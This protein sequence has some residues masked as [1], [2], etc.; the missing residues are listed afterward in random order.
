MTGLSCIN[1]LWHEFNAPDKIPPDDEGSKDRMQTGIEVGHL[2]KKLHPKGIEI[3]YGS[4]AVHLTKEALKKRVPLFEASFCYKDCYCKVDL[5]V[6]VHDDEWDLYEVK[7]TTSAKGEHVEDVA[8][9]RYVLQKDGIKIRRAHVMFINNE[10]VKKGAIDVKK[11]FE[12]EDVTDL[13]DKPD[14][15]EANVERFLH[16]INGKK[17][18]IVYGQDC[19]SP[20]ECPI[21][22]QDIE[23]FELTKLVGFG[24]KFYPFLN[25]GITTFKQ[26]PK[27][28]KLTNKQ[29]IQLTS[30]P[31]T[32]KVAVKKFLDELTYPLY[33][34]DFESFAHAMPIHDGTRP[35]QAV[36]FQ[37][38]LHVIDKDKVEHREF[39]ADGAKDPRKELIKALKMIGS[40]G[41]V[42]M[43]TGFERKRLEELADYSKKDSKWIHKIIERLADL[44]DPF[45]TFDVYDPKQEG[46]YSIKA[47]LPAFIG[48]SYAEL[49]IGEGT[50][51]QR[52][53]LRVTYGKVSKEEKE[54]IRKALLTYCKHDTEAMVKLVNVL[55]SISK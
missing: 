6:P 36:P 5:L 35:Y 39:L 32:N 40:K 20:S 11:F 27:D 28:L 29:H 10:F 21:C 19:A 15:V 43:Y 53:Y 14:E 48:I 16:I 55:R 31:N 7:S 42:L 13:T 12:S 25:Q 34:L 26:L 51:A 49:D 37:F 38:S 50:M 4:G 17:P 33:C 52:E 45:R 1:L 44:S 24:K 41:S 9:Q 30:K 46:S 8:F 2:A 22:S 3:P 23:P 18:K 54:K 47:V